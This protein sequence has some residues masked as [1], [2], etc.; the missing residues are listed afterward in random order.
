MYNKNQYFGKKN[1]VQKSSYCHVSNFNRWMTINDVNMTLWVQ[2]LWS[3]IV[4]EN[5]LF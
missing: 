1:N 3:C 2:L 4:I 5:E